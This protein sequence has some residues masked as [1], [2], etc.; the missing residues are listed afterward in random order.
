MVP[1]FS[2]YLSFLNFQIVVVSVDQ[3][4]WWPQNFGFGP[5]PAEHPALGLV[6]LA[7][8]PSQICYWSDP[9]EG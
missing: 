5:R 1:K 2:Y 7:A 9:Q 6:A 4:D 3:V 8:P